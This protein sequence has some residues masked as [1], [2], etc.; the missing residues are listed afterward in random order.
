M[1]EWLNNVCN[2][3][4]ATPPIAGTRGAFLL[5]MRS[6]L[7]LATFAALFQVCRLCRCCLVLRHAACCCA[8]AAAAITAAAACICYMGS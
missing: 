7:V 4:S 2:L 5:V 6:S 3:P 8:A 1:V